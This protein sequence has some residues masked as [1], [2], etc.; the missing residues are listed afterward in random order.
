MSLLLGV[1]LSA[2]AGTRDY[3]SGDLYVARAIQ[4]I[5]APPWEE[6]MEFATY[7]G[8]PGPMMAGGLTLFGWFLWKRQ[9]AEYLAVAVALL[10]LGVNPLLKRLVERPRPTDE[11]LSIWREQ[12]GLSFPSGHAFTAMLLFG[13]LYYLAPR[14]VPRIGAIRLLRAGSLAMILLIGVSRV[15]LGAHW[16]SDVLGGFLFGGIVLAVVVHIH[17]LIAPREVQP[18]VC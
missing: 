1:L 12:S 17:R 11:L 5:H 18:G 7:I 6:V 8:K 16:P 2:A 13:L 4:G 9:R 15:Y 3:F 14:L 10:G